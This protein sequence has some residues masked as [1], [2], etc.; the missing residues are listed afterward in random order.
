M[1]PNLSM[2]TSFVFFRNSDLRTAHEHVLNSFIV[3]YMYIHL[4]CLCWTDSYQESK[5]G[6]EK[7]ES[8][9]SSCCRVIKHR[10]KPSH[11]RTKRKSLIIIRIR[12]ALWRKLNNLKPLFRV[13]EEH[14][15]SKEVKGNA[16]ASKG[17]SCRPETTITAENAC[18]DLSVWNKRQKSHLLSQNV[19]LQR[20]NL[21]ARDKFIRT[22]SILAWGKS[23]V[24][25][26]HFAFTLEWCFF[27]LV[28]IMYLFE[29]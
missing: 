15:I 22:S 11:S 21:P 5:P 25:P 16:L 14:C 27:H 7:R 24:L 3:A 13:N 1:P 20:Y 26:T 23:R 17:K 2:S 10:R 18:H 4:L 8:E 29:K 19:F 9:V 28:F 12:E 6:N